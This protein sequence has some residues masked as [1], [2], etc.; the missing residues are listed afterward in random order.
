MSNAG[1]YHVAWFTQGKARS[2]VFYAN[3]HNQGK[4]YSL[5]VRVGSEDANVSRPYLIKLLDERAIP[6]RK[7]GKHRRIRIEDVMRYKLQIDN[8][9]E[10]VLDQLVEEAQKHDMGYTHS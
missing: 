2:G 10:S 4:S 8:E 1:T 3:S 9:R 7:L 5:P 6:F